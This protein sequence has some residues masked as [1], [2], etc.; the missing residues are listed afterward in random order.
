MWSGVCF[1]EKTSEV[2]SMT[3]FE[4]NYPTLGVCIT[5]T[6]YWW[7]IVSDKH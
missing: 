7:N 5:M 4:L 6:S 1:A 3:V 2:V